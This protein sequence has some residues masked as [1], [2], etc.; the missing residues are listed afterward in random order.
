MRAQSERLRDSHGDSEEFDRN[1]GDVY[2]DLAIKCQPD[3]ERISDDYGFYRLNEAAVRK[4]PAEHLKREYG[5]ELSSEDA[6]LLTEMVDAIR[7]ERPVKYFETK[8]ERPVGLEEFAV[9]V[10]PEGIDGELRQAL[11][12]AGLHIETYSPEKAGDRQ[13]AVAQASNMDG[14]RFHAAMSRGVEDFRE[15]QRK[16]VKERG[17]VMPGLKEAEVRVVN[18]SRHDFTGE[19]PIAE[20]R[21]WAKENIVGKHELTD[22]EGRTV[23]YSISGKAID[24]Y[25]S[26]SAIDKSENLGVH[27]SVLKMLPEVIGESIE[28][29]VHPDYNKDADGVRRVENSYKSGALVHRFYGAVTVDGVIYRIKP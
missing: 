8:Y 24:K 25:L 12:N 13:R 7:R 29:E 9:A 5:I 19:R 21:K 4:D 18:V 16:A 22:S 10:V 6:G 1:W 17:S 27:L 26:S 14:V 3:A 2:Y 15:R 11:E 28:A 20:A 23:P